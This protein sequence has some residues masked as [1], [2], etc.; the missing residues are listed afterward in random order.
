MVGTAIKRS[1]DRMRQTKVRYHGGLC[2][3]FVLVMRASLPK[4][5]TESDRR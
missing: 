1:G 2:L 3:D 4:D 5:R